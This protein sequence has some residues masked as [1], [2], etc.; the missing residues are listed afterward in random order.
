MKGLNL[1][2]QHLIAFW[3]KIISW[4]L[5]LKKSEK[6]GGNEKRWKINCISITKGQ[7][8]QHG[9]CE[10]MSGQ[11]RILPDA[12][13][14]NFITQRTESNN[15]IS[16]LLLPIHKSGVYRWGKKLA[17]WFII[18]SFLT[19]EYRFSYGIDAQ[20]LNKPKF[21]YG[22]NMQTTIK[23]SNIIIMQPGTQATGLGMMIGRC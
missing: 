7:G 1:I 3:G 4:I 21:W 10:I 15:S 19:K 17:N 9:C 8:K 18:I 20:I 12:E 13:W 11:R 6:V 14:K 16:K 5:K 22:H 2:S 23:M